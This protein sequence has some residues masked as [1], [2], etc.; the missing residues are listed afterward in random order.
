MY[1]IESLEY[2]KGASLITPLLN[3]KNKNVKSRAFLSLIS[4]KPNKLETLIDF[5]H[6]IT[7]AEEINIMDILHQKKTKIPSNLSE[8]IVSDNDSIIKLGIK[9]MIFYNYTNDNE[10]IVKLLKHSTNLFVTKQLQQ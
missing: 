10:T 2:K 3:H 9:L 8:W 1:Q 5:S 7:I 6:Q 4:L